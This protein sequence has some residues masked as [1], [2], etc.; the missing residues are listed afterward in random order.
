M[1]SDYLRLF[2]LY[3]KPLVGTEFVLPVEITHPIFSI[4][5]ATLFFRMFKVL[6]TALPRMAYFVCGAHYVTTKGK[7]VSSSEAPI[8]CAAPH[9]SYL[10]PIVGLYITQPPCV[11]STKENGNMPLIGSELSAYIAYYTC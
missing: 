2:S 3:F 11:I 6:N 8:L 5:T 4:Y 7:R 9:S 1:Y 10:D